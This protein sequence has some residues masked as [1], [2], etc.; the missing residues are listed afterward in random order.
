[1]MVLCKQPVYPIL[2]TM[3][4]IKARMKLYQHK[5]DKANGNTRAQAYDIDKCVRFVT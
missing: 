1:M 2:L 4:I 5:N 3:K